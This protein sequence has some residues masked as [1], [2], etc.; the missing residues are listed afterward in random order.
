MEGE[1]E[2]FSG[3]IV[4]KILETFSSIGLP[5]RQ[6]SATISPKAV[7]LGRSLSHATVARMITSAI[8]SAKRTES[9]EPFTMNLERVSAAS[10]RT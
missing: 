7:T 9:G 8:N 4:P 10:S 1:N 5:A 3:Q 2:L 6:S